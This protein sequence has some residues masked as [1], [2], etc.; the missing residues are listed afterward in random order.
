L[1]PFG[2]T[3]GT[4]KVIDRASFLV[5]KSAS[6]ACTNFSRLV[7]VINITVILFSI[8]FAMITIYVTLYKREQLK[9]YLKL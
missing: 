5:P 9:K 3:N 2:E 8:I 1:E 6:K 4:F 7:F